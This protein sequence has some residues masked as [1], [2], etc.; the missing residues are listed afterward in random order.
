MSPE[1]KK[2]IAPESD[3][4]LIKV[5][6]KRGWV[7]I[8]NSNGSSQED[9]TKKWQEQVEIAR[10]LIE[11]FLNP[12]TPDI[13][14][15]INEGV[16]RLVGEIQTFPGNRIKEEINF[17]AVKTQLAVIFQRTLTDE[18]PPEIKVIPAKE[19]QPSF[20]R[21]PYAEQVV[22]VPGQIIYLLSKLQLPD[23]TPK[24]QSQIIAIG[25]ST[26]TTSTYLALGKDPIL[27][28]LLFEI[29]G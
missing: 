13:Q 19:G 16:M 10:P 9:P 3:R 22:I 7:F 24:T 12:S 25:G 11:S 5:L 1:Y 20:Q 18:I 2:V 14:E 29:T 28:D 8:E 6:I 23:G 17:E 4:E 26:P 15:Q 21:D 27:K